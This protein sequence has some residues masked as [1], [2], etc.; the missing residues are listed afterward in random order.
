MYYPSYCF[1][2]SDFPCFFSDEH[3]KVQHRFS[4]FNFPA[5]CACSGCVGCLPHLRA[6]SLICGQAVDGL[7]SIKWRT[8]LKNVMSKICRPYMN[9]EGLK[10]GTGSR[11]A[12][13]HFVLK[14]CLFQEKK[15]TS[16]KMAGRLAIFRELLLFLGRK[17]SY[18]IEPPSGK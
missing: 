12:R 18:L 6:T 11:E 15:L 14:I 9:L 7:W 2:S 8:E 4:L 16:Q 10:N 17:S 1:C 5:V 3:S 13:S